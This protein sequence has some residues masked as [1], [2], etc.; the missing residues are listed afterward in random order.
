MNDS[1]M[2]QLNFDDPRFLPFEGTGVDST[3]QLQFSELM[4]Q[5]IFDSINDI[6]MEVRYTSEQGSV[7]SEVVTA[8]KSLDSAS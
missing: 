1:G 3:W 6:I 2:F 7:Q 4:P 8:I 5:A